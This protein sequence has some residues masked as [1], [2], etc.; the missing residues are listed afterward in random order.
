[1]PCKLSSLITVMRYPNWGKFHSPSTETYCLACE[2]IQSLG[3]DLCDEMQ[4]GY[5]IS[6]LLLITDR[7]DKTMNE[8]TA[9]AVL[10]ESFLSIRGRC[11]RSLRRW[12]EWTGLSIRAP[13]DEPLSA[14]RDRSICAENFAAGLIGPRRT[15]SVTVFT[16]V[17]ARLRQK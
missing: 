2:L 13:L 12:T 9:N 3:S 14:Q 10:D 7:K 4:I 11:W 15:N 5:N 1:M 8:R 17:L 6:L 16:K